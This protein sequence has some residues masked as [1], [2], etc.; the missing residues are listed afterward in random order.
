[1]DFREKLKVDIDKN[2]KR[3]VKKYSYKDR[4]EFIQEGKKRKNEREDR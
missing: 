3:F 4:K 1:M 2:A